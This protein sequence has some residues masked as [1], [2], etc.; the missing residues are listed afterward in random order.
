MESMDQRALTGSSL[1]N[2]LVF[3]VKELR[4]FEKGGLSPGPRHC[5]EQC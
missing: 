3:S 4:L 2:G 1:S 5:S